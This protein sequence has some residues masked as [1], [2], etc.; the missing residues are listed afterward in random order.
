M[1]AVLRFMESLRSGRLLLR[2]VPSTCQVESAGESGGHPMEDTMSIED[3]LAIHDVIAQYSHS[4][5]SQDAAAFAKLFVEAGV[6][7]IFVPGQARPALRLC[8]RVMI[9]E[10]AARRLRGRRG[11]LSSRHHQSGILFDEL[12]ANSARTRTMV[13]VTHQDRTEAAPRPIASG[14]YHD[15]WRKTKAGWRL[16]RRAAHLDG[17]VGV[18][19]RTTRRG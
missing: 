8:S 11:R 1:R 7:E 13:L 17:V 12:T 6:F 2:I 14:V 9:R 15:R 5:D 18:T 10:W 3:R 19:S 16:A 4:Y